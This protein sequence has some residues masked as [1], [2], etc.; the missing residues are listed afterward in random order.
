MENITFR[1]AT[2]KDATALFE[3]KIKAYG[4]EFNL[5]NYAEQGYKEAVDDCQIDNAKMV[6]CLAV[7]GMKRF[8]HNSAIGL[9]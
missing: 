4:D 3:A 6:E 1:P 9:W 7:I 2:P 8:V 5:F